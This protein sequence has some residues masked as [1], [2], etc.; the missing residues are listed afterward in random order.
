MLKRALIALAVILVAF[1]AGLYFAINR[2]LH[3]DLVRS[4]LEAQL[5]ARLGQPVHIGSAGASLFPPSLDLRDITIG[6]VPSV[7]L[8]HVQIV[9]GLRGLLSRRIEEAEIVLASGQVAW[10]LP[11]TLSPQRAPNEP[12]R[13]RRR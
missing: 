1:T 5:A 6:K 12:V 3:G 11:F 8:A 4:T 10:P 13:R 9:T 7:R 2:G